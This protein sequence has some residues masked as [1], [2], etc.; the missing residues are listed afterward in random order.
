[1]GARECADKPGYRTMEIG[2]NLWI[3]VPFGD[4]EEF[5]Q[6]QQRLDR[7]TG[8]VKLLAP[9]E[10]GVLAVDWVVLCGPRSLGSSETE[11]RS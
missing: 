5:P 6:I 4:A 7:D 9:D 11:P 3:L 8:R 2:G 10:V 1:M